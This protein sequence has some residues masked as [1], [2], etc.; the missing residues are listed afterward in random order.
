MLIHKSYK[1]RLYP[2]TQQEQA[3]KQILGTC[4]FV[5]N[6][7]LAKRNDEYLSNKKNLTYYRCSLDLTQLRKQSDYQ[8]LG[9][10]QI[11]PLQQ[12]LRDLDV[13]YNNFFR[14]LSRYPKFKSKKDSTQSFRKPTSWKIVGTRVQLEK[15][16]LIKARGTFPP[17]KS[18]F[19][20][21]TITYKSTG[22]WWAIINT[23]QEITPPARIGEPMGIDVGILNLATTSRGQKYI[24]PNLGVYKEKLRYHQ[25]NL[26]RKQIGSK[27]RERSK[28]V[29]ARAFEKVSNVQLNHLHQVSHDI[30]SE[31]QAIVVCEN[32]DVIKMMKTHSVA[33]Y[34]SGI[35]LGN[36]LKQLEYKQIWNGGE[37]RQVNRF[38]PSSKTCSNC[39]FVL[40][41]LSPAT[42]EW[43]CSKCGVFHDR[44][45]N[46]AKNILKQ[47]L[48]LKPRSG[49]RG[50]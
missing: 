12:S 43:T 48:L 29:V 28:V 5:W 14:G 13:A 2:T 35:G 22:Q 6:Y 40:E 39:G 23:E 26:A 25:R 20:F 1:L 3:L 16:L 42:R 8:W 27:R 36:F 31:N 18:K 38:F 50:E 10:T 45:I 24:N 7:Y 21:I 33:K 49:L 34:L 17:P 30:I 41:R 11:R 47:G 15:H 37:F 19:H 32:L 44:D 46:A 9:E 4:R